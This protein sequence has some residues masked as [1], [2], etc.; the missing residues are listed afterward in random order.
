GTKPPRFESRALSKLILQ[1]KPCRSVCV[2]RVVDG[3]AMPH[4]ARNPQ[5][6][7]QDHELMHGLVAQLPYATARAGSVASRELRQLQIGFLQQECGTRSST[8]PA[9][10]RRFQKDSR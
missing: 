3:I 9:Y 7:K 4:V 6:A 2:S 10:G 1:P 8:T 5:A